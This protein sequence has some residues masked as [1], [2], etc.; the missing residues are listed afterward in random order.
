MIEIEELVR[1]YREAAVKTDTTRNPRQQHRWFDRL[2]KTYKALRSSEQGRQ[3]LVE[4]LDDGDMSVRC[5]AAA[6]SL[7][8]VSERAR[9]ILEIIRDDN[10]PCSM[11]AKYTLIEYDA[12]R[13]T[14]DF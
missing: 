13:L 3:R 7:D 6:H 12:G 10:G 4:L 11:S 5:W 2:H 8:Y 1:D 9:R 14:F